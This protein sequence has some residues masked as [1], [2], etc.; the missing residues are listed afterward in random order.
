MRIKATQ[1]EEVIRNMLNT[2]FAKINKSLSDQIR[3]EFKLRKTN[4][5]R[6]EYFWT[7]SPSCVLNE[8]DAL[9]SCAST[10]S[11]FEFKDSLKSTNL[12][13][14]GNEFFKKA[15]F[16]EAINKYNESLRYSV[17][18][19]GNLALTLAN[20][21][22]VF[23]KLN[24]YQLCLNDI[25]SAL[26]HR[27]PKNLIMKLYERKIECFN[28]LNQL[29]N[30]YDFVDGLDDQ[31]KEILAQKIK[32]KRCDEEEERTSNL[33]AI[34]FRANTLIPSASD[35]IMIDSSESDGKTNQYNRGSQHTLLNKMFKET[36]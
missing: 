28:M 21:S 14:E 2:T 16:D 30:A 22:I 8:L 9:I 36:S 11:E 20:R 5:E 10:Q 7:N 13:K 17:I 19:E 29:K 27:Y 15:L 18:D 33:R 25:D 4:F 1:L 12:R 34:R 24:D 32:L 26:R 31:F 35:K 23:F 6:F 3:T